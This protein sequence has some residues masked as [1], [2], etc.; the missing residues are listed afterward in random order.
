MAIVE[1][2][3][4]Q[5]FTQINFSVETN[6][7]NDQFN[8]NSNKECVVDLNHQNGTFEFFLYVE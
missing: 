1:T 2:V 6:G 3:V 7:S 8:L 5:E 4:T